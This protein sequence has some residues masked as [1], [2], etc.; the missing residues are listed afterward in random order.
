MYDLKKKEVLMD[1]A[2]EIKYSEVHVD[3]LS[4]R[5]AEI[6]T[7]IGLPDSF[8][9]YIN[10]EPEKNY[11]G[12]SLFDRINIFEKYS[13][14]R[15]DFKGL[16]LFGRSGDGYLVITSDGE[17]A[18]FDI[19]REELIPVNLGGGMNES[20]D[21][22]NEIYLKDLPNR[23]EAG[24]PNIAGVIGLGVAI[25]YLNRIGMDNIAIVEE[26]L[27]EYMVGELSKIPD[28]FDSP[29]VL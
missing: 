10:I 28:N 23:L 22:V 3:F 16:C 18:F 20:F 15:E 25:D 5:D 7:K 4:E 6:L 21:S 27:K 26:K 24:T 14:D 12:Y 13:L 2:E 9:P 11:G 17:V 29:K 1:M 8:A 19:D